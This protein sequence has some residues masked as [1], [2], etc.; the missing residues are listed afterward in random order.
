MTFYAH[1]NV[2]N[3]GV[4]IFSCS[5]TR[6]LICGKIIIND[7]VSVQPQKEIEMKTTD[8]F[9]PKE[10][11]VKYSDETYFEDGG[12]YQFGIVEEAVELGHLLSK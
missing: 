11:A 3:L 12:T 2:E 5:F 1:E 9:T 4:Y 6:A 8:M 10:Q 7:V